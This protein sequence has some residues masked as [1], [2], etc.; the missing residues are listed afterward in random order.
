[1]CQYD[2]Q[3]PF[4]Q[5]TGNTQP[6]NRRTPLLKDSAPT[7]THKKQYQT[8]YVRTVHVIE[9]SK[10]KPCTYDTKLNVETGPQ[11]PAMLVL[12]PRPYITHHCY[13]RL[14]TY[15][16]VACS[17]GV[18]P[19]TETI[20]TKQEYCHD[21]VF[22]SAP[23]PKRPDGTAFEHTLKLELPSSSVQSGIG[24]T[25]RGNNMG[26]YHTYT[27]LCQRAIESRAR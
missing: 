27:R 2:W 4:A 10:V 9:R 18:Y 13:R 12:Q 3:Y 25:R 5:R 26:W 15:E 14:N 16:T 11:V 7:P 6:Q 17:K 20:A 1:M 8:K 19:F 24:R 22:S 23:E 21:F